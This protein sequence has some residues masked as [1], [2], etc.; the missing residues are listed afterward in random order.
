MG[1]QKRKRREYR[2]SRKEQFRRPEVGFSLYE[3]RTRGKR[4]KYTYSDDEDFYTDSTNRRSTRNTRNHTPMDSGPI[5]TASG[6]QSRPVARLNAETLSNGATSAPGSVLGDAHL[7]G[8]DIDMDEDGDEIGPTGRPRR[9]AAVNHG[10]NGWAGENKK[11]RKDYLS[12]D[13][14]EDSE[15]DFGDDEEDDHVPDEEDDDEEE[16]EDDRESL[17]EDDLG[18]SPDSSQSRVVKLRI[19]VDFDKD[20]KAS[21]MANAKPKLQDTPSA[22]SP[23]DVRSPASPSGDSGSPASPLQISTGTPERTGDVVNVAFKRK[24]PDP[25]PQMPND[26]E[27]SVPLTPSGG[28][29]TSLAFRGSPDKVQHVPRPI[30]IVNGE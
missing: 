11:R 28:V 26:V 9:S 23:S 16:F 1:W 8:D 10:M 5:I 13:E 15:P 27:P 24:T 7:G 20:G 22:T 4:A 14:D 29:S 6:R 18:D 25:A 17:D 12:D 30:N 19:K 21:R 2:R 3:G